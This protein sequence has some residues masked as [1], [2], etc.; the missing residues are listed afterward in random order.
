MA[1]VDGNVALSWVT[2]GCS[3]CDAGVDKLLAGMWANLACRG[4][5]KWWERVSSGSNLA[6][7]PSKGL[8]P[9]CP[10]GWHMWEMVSVQRWDPDMDGVG[11]PRPVPAVKGVWG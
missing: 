7:R 11:P 1:F 10:R 5:F 9:E 4:G 6:D 3:N 2:R 8:V